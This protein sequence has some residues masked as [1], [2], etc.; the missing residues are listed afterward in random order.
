[1]RPLQA[2]DMAQLRQV[3]SAIAAFR[4]QPASAQMRKRC[5]FE[6]LTREEAELRQCCRRTGRMVAAPTSQA[7]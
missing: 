6:A 7:A 5:L 3:Q 2:L 4:S 1:M